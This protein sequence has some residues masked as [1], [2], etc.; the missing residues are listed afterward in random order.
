MVEPFCAM[1][2]D[3]GWLN[4]GLGSV[5]CYPQSG[6]APRLVANGAELVRFSSADARAGRKNLEEA[7]LKVDRAALYIDTLVQRVRVLRPAVIAFEDYVVY[8]S[9]SVAKLKE[10]S[11]KLLGL[12][13]VARSSTVYSTVEE[14]QRAFQQPKTL[15]MLL[16]RADELA[17]GFAD[18]DVSDDRGDAGRGDAA[19]TLISWGVVRTVA[20]LL[21]VPVYA[22]APARVATRFRDGKRKGKRGTKEGLLR[23]LPA[24]EA[25][26]SALALGDDRAESHCYDGGALAVLGAETYLSYFR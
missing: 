21:E 13:G 10:A 4:M 14:L 11:K 22:F 19:N 6:A 8:D 20:R 26:V 16:E 9:R 2:V 12:F 3:L 25:Q 15:Q 23:E 17:K 1:G 7:Q 24:F 18:A 5:V